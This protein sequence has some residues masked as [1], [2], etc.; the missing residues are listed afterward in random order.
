MKTRDVMNMEMESRLEYAVNATD[1]V[2]GNFHVGLGA[3]RNDDKQKFH[4]S[5]SLK[6][7][8][9]LDI[10]TSTE[11]IYPQ[12]DRWDYAVEYNGETFFIDIHP[13]S[14]SEVEIVISKLNWLKQWLK[15]KAP[16]INT[17]KPHNKPPYY[18]IYTNTKE[19][20]I[21]RN[22]RYGRL[23]AQNGLKPVNQCD[24]SLL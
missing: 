5:N 9:S 3:I 4:E 22:S 12:D 23:L 16:C 8:G 6:I 14:T 13:G 1:D 17:L 2:K 7:Q 21:L 15:E 11:S 19:Y 18:W 20:A 24:F 10:E